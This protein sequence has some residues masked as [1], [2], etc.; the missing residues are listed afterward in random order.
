MITGYNE[1]SG[2][3]YTFNLKI[4]PPFTYDS[5][6]PSRFLQSIEKPNCTK[7]NASLC[8]FGV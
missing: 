8:R 3:P 2:K 6:P 7:L 4:V 5:V 1:V